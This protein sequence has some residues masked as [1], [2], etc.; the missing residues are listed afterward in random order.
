MLLDSSRT[1]IPDEARAHLTEYKDDPGDGGVKDLSIT[2]KIYMDTKLER[3][4]HPESYHH[5]TRHY[6]DMSRKHSMLFPFHRTR[7]VKLPPG[8]GERLSAEGKAELERMRKEDPP[9]PKGG[10]KYEFDGPDV[11]PWHLRPVDERAD[12]PKAKR[13]RTFSG[14][15][16]FSKPR[17]TTRRRT[18][19]VTSRAHS[20]LRSPSPEPQSPPARATSPESSKMSTGRS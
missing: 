5:L 16:R 20:A 10:F 9:K 13:P 6:A 14:L 3:M 2:N 1:H 17:A 8:E 15:H 19:R 12:P 11:P 7:L 18:G 4:L